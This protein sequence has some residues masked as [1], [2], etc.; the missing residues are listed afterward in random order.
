MLS[1]MCYPCHKPSHVISIFAQR[2]WRKISNLEM[3]RLYKR[4]RKVR[5]CL[6]MV[7]AIDH[8]TLQLVR[9][10]FDLLA[11]N[12]FNILIILVFLKCCV[13]F[14]IDSYAIMFAGQRR[15][16]RIFRR[17][18]DVGAFFDYFERTYIN[19]SF[20]PTTWN[21]FRRDMDNRTNNHVEG[22]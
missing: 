16:R 4:Q 11:G 3:T 1:V 19:G 21:V 5:K 6:R 14:L 10:N 18:P 9:T 17:Y 13:I 20:H 15:T 7:M 12:I 22:I 2:L 8:L